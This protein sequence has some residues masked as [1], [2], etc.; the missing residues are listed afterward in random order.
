MPSHPGHNLIRMG[1]LPPCRLDANEPPGLDECP[2]GRSA[3]DAR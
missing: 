1:K 3:S 2:P